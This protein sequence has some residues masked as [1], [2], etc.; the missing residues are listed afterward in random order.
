MQVVAI[1]WQV[2]LLTG[3][4]L[5]IG[6]LG[7]VRVV[8]VIVFSLWGGVVADRRD[9]R[10]VL[11]VSRSAMTLAAVALS[12]LTFFHAE[13][14]GWLYLLT[15]VSAAAVAAATP[16]IRNYRASSNRPTE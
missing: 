16:V 6:L 2:Y 5:A 14:K 3:S 13:T 15:A 11:L 7:L 1:N 8:P 12:G 10:N 4:P 9:R